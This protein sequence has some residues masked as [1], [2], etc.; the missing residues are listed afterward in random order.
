M[1]VRYSDLLMIVYPNGREKGHKYVF[2]V[3]E[4]TWRLFSASRHY[5]FLREA[6]NHLFMCFIVICALPGYISFLLLQNWHKPSSLK[7]SNLLSLSFQGSEVKTQ[8]DWI[9]CWR[10]EEAEMKVREGTVVLIW[11]LGYISNSLH[12]DGRIISLWL[13]EGDHRGPA[14]Y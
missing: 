8:Y 1:Y 12:D 11:A 9:L 13:Y 5:Y 4:C 10:P 2:I 6:I 7:N 3:H 14:N